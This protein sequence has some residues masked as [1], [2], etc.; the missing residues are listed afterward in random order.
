MTHPVINI[1]Y[2][3]HILLSTTQPAYDTYDHQIDVAEELDAFEAQVDGLQAELKDK[4]EEIGRLEDEAI[5][6]KNSISNLYEKLAEE[7]EK[8][9]EQGIWCRYKQYTAILTLP[10]LTHVTT[11]PNPNP[12]NTPY[13]QTYSFTNLLPRLL[14]LSL[15][16]YIHTLILS[17]QSNLSIQPTTPRHDTIKDEN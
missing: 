12:N 8:T 17:Y 11:H 6:L 4:N 9:R 14:I 13:L 2:S 15:N 16:A 3:W 7:Q 1:L 5:N 10:H